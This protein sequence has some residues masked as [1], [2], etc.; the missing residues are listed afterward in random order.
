MRTKQPRA[1]AKADATILEGRHIADRDEPFMGQRRRLGAGGLNESK[2]FE[3]SRIADD[4]GC[5][6][7]SLARTNLD[8]DDAADPF[9]GRIV[10]GCA[11]Q[12]GEVNRAGTV[13]G[14]HRGPRPLPGMNRR[15]CSRTQSSPASVE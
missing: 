7:P 6:L 9:T 2:P 13:R 14:G 5:R 11:N 15:M 12:V 1:L 4:E 8:I 10:D 3:H